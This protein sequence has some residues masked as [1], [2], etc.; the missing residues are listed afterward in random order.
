MGHSEKLASFGLEEAVKRAGGQSAL[1]KAVGVKQGHVWDWLNSQ[2]VPTLRCA[3]IE[4]AT[5][6]R[7][8]EL[9]PDLHWVRDGAEVIGIVDSINTDITPEYVAQCIRNQTAPAQ[10]GSARPVFSASA[11]NTFGDRVAAIIITD[12]SKSTDGLLQH[13]GLA[14]EQINDM[15]AGW[16]EPQPGSKHAARIAEYL[17]VREEWLLSGTGPG[18]VFMATARRQGTAL[19]AH[20]MATDRPSAIMP[21]SGEPFA[22]L[23]ERSATVDSCLTEASVLLN[24]AHAIFEHECEE[25]T[26]ATYGAWQL[27][28]MARRLVGD[29][30]LKLMAYEGEKQA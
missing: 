16:L 10:A 18:P 8:E 29:A 20:E 22:F 15:Y 21:V 14:R 27:M 30:H 5:G 25:F 12:P 13:A 6:V 17:G 2:V 23:V 26:A 3:A 24:N 7:C 28:E 11:G 4:A 1:A 9:R 19:D